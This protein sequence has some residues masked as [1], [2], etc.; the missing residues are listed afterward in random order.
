MGIESLRRRKQQTLT[1]ASHDELFAA[2]T[3]RLPMAMYAPDPGGERLP[4]PS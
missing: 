4:G 1:H 3:L 2:Y